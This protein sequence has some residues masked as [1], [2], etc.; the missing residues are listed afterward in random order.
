MGVDLLNINGLKDLEPPHR[1]PGI[2]RGLRAFPQGT[3]ELAWR[4]RVVL[5]DVLAEVDGHLDRVAAGEAG[6][7]GEGAKRERSSDTLLGHGAERFR[8]VGERR[9]EVQRDRVVIAVPPERVADTHES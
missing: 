2:D 3:L 6:E 9:L 4:H 7:A 1:I 8:P 5:E